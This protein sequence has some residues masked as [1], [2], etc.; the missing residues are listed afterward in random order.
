MHLKMS[1]EKWSPSCLR[2]NVLILTMSLTHL[3]LLSDGD[4][5]LKKISF[6]EYGWI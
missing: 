2:L 4:N 5:K 6:N 1:S 3:S